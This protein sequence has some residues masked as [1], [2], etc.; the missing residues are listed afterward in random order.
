MQTTE[1]SR[2]MPSISSDMRALYE[3]H[4]ELVWRYMA[5]RSVRQAEID[6]LVHKVF[7]VVREHPRRHQMQQNVAVLVCMVARQVLR[8]H[9]RREVAA[10]KLD[11]GDALTEIF[12]RDAT[13][14]LVLGGLESMTDIEREAY[15][16]CEGEGMSTEDVALAI[17][18]PEL[19]VQRKRARAIRQ[20]NEF[21]AKMRSCGIARTPQLAVE[22]D[23]IR[24]LHEACTPTERDRDRVFAAMIAHSIGAGATRST[25]RPAAALDSVPSPSFAAQTAPSAQEA[26]PRTLAPSWPPPLADPWRSRAWWVAAL[27]VS[28]VFVSLGSGIWS[29]THAAGSPSA[30]RVTTDVKSRAG[31]GA[32]REAHAAAAL[33]AAP[34]VA[35]K[36]A[37]QERPAQPVK[38]AAPAVEAR[39]ATREQRPEPQKGDD[40]RTRVDEA[41]LLF[42]A[43]HAY[44]YGNAALALQTITKHRR[45][46]PS[47]AY[48]VERRVLHGQILC[49]LARYREAQRQMLELEAMDANPAALAAVYRVCSGDGGR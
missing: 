5:E 31:A 17:G 18:V 40:K 4:F 30:M 25:H 45:S 20:M 1:Q 7:R 23:L 26:T 8:E 16:L 13:S 33:A 3:A 15:L 10:S 28:L 37:A 2:V 38:A 6:D 47:T 35:P 36:V 24:S 19:A 46:Y 43:E 32:A 9:Q 34:K 39:R 22:Q 11:D 48:D 49:S 12:E 44:R 14:E 29:A 41:K 27:A 21:L 42:A